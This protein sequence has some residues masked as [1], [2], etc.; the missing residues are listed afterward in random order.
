MSLPAP[1]RNHGL[2]TADFPWKAADPPTKRRQ[3]LRAA[4]RERNVTS[5]KKR[6]NL[7]RIYQRRNRV[8]SAFEDDM[9]WMDKEYGGSTRPVCGPVR[10]KQTCLDARFRSKEQAKETEERHASGQAV[11][12]QHKAALVKMGRLRRNDGRYVAACVPRAQKTV[13]NQ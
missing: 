12:P 9:L 1:S 2:G 8:C 10:W 7:I 11:D 5:V 6:L 3:A 13:E 4:V